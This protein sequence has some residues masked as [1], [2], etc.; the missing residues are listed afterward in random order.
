MRAI[1]VDDDPQAR[2]ILLAL[3]QEYCPQVEVVGQ[4]EDVPTGVRT[5]HALNP[6]IVFLDIEM[7]GYLGI[8]LPEFFDNPSFDI[9]FT[10][11][12]D[13]YAL[14]AFEIAA[15]DYLLKP[16]QIDR[17]EQAVA[18]AA[19][20]RANPQTASRLLAF[21]ESLQSETGRGKIVLPI[22]EGYLF[23][24]PDEILYLLADRSYTTI[25]L[26]ENRQV[27]VSRTLKEFEQ[28]LTYP[29]FFRANR[30]CILNLDHVQQFLR[31][32][33]GTIVM[34]DNTQFSLSENRREA[35]LK[36]FSG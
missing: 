25:H 1:L 34:D 32:D 28:L 11:A 22:A 15:I 33:S 4:A 36:A 2:R 9:I 17:L 3:L 31:K 5:I 12:H 14:R 29:C 18:K 20:N 10:T 19:R 30:S 23:V 24:R 7:P 21:Q 8:Q 16:I 26:L 35:F 6:D 13:G 27:V